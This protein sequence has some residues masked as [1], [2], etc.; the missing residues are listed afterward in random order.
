MRILTNLIVLTICAILA[1]GCKTKHPSAD[2]R[3]ARHPFQESRMSSEPAEGY[4]PSGV[5][6]VRG[7][8]NTLYLVGT[9]H[10]VTD[11]Q[12]PFPSPFYAAYRNA[13]EIY[14]EVDM[15]HPSFWWNLRLTFRVL[16]WYKSHANE[17]VC[18]KGKTLSNYVS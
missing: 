12:I 18:P 14:A 11:D 13:E 5:F 4:T 17:L 7:G 1:A 16:K 3:M 10:I 9:C 6:R 2:S 8:R 15:T